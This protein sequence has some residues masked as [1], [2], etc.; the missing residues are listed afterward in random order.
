MTDNPSTR[1]MH[2]WAV[3]EDGPH[4]ITSSA[5]VNFCKIGQQQTKFVHERQNK[6]FLSFG[7]TRIHCK[8]GIF[9]SGY[10]YGFSGWKD[11]GALSKFTGRGIFILFYDS[12][13]NVKPPNNI[14][15][16]KMRLGAWIRCQVQ[17]FVFVSGPWHPIYL[18]GLPVTSPW[19]PL[20]LLR[21]ISLSGLIFSWLA[22]NFYL[23]E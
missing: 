8:T 21:Q 7:P 20:S 5:A 14:W 15:P 23:R 13:A 12:S 4:N 9:F 16:K 17:G 11:R 19:Y 1:A 6:M 3:G 22:A 18:R 10:C 2:T